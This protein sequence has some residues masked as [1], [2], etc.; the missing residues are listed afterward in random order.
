VKRFDEREIAA[1]RD[2]FASLSHRATPEVGCPTPDHIWEAAHGG[3]TQAETHEVIDHTASCGVCAEAWRIACAVETTVGGAVVEA[4]RWSWRWMAVAAAAV[5]VLVAGATVQFRSRQAP[6]AA[7]YREARE[8]VIRSLVPEAEALPRDAFVLRWTPGPEGSRY[9][10][11]VARSDLT[12][13]V[14]AKGLSAAEQRIEPSVI[15]T[16]PT[17]DRLLWQVEMI[18]PDGRRTQS[19][20]FVTSLR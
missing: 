13:L 12:E 7:T 4:R 2:A 19:A 5:V 20:T 8:D 1:L 10:L 6:P 15:S 9:N 16:V 11:R 14:H 18:L 3:L 17:G